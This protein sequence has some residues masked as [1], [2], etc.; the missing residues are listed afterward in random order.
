MKFVVLGKALSVHLTFV[1][2][3]TVEE[4]LMCDHSNETQQQFPMVL[5][6]CYALQCISNFKIR[7]GCMGL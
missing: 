3:P 4:I 2:F 6:Y 7:Y 5:F 1:T